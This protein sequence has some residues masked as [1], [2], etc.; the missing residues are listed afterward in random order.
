MNIAAHKNVTLRGSPLAP[1]AVP[2]TWRSIMPALC[3]LLEEANGMVLHHGL[4]RVFGMGDTCACRNALSWN[5]A[6]WRQAFGLPES[7]VLWGEN[8]FGDQFGVESG[9][10]LVVRLSCEGGR[11]DRLPY[12]SPCEQIE[13]MLLE[14]PRTWIEAD[15]VSAAFRRGLRPLPTEHLSFEVPLV[16]GGTAA[17]DNLEVLDGGAHMDVLGQIVEQNRGV[18]EGTRIGGVRG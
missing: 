10:G 14:D 2:A 3:A 8:V 18:P 16:C 11:L 17:E 13:S 4:F 7:I 5:R 9:S 12:R 15:L 6:E 1:S